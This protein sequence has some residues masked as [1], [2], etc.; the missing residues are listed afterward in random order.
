M[1]AAKA[2]AGIG[3]GAPQAAVYVPS[4]RVL[5]RVRPLP[6]A[7]VYAVEDTA[8]SGPLS[9]DAEKEAGGSESSTAA[10]GA[11]SNEAV[12]AESNAPAPEFHRGTLEKEG[13]PGHDSQRPEGD[14]ESGGGRGGVAHE[15]AA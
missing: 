15:E 7:A 8:S 9:T 3:P 12:G 11:E 4:R 13:A 10:V 14:R 1:Y 6:R 5:R 2:T